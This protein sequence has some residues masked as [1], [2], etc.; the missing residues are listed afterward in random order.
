MDE[1]TIP[2]IRNLTVRD[3]KSA[4]R[5][6]SI[7]TSNDEDQERVPDQTTSSIGS[8]SSSS[9]ASAKAFCSSV[10]KTFLDYPE[11]S[12]DQNF[13]HWHSSF[14]G[15]ANIHEYYEILDPATIISD[16]QDPEFKAKSKF[17]FTVFRMTLKSP[18]TI[19]LVT[20]HNHTCDACALYADLLLEFSKENPHAEISIKKLKDALGKTSLDGSWK[21]SF[22]A[23]F[24]TFTRRVATLEQ[25]RLIMYLAHCRL[26]SDP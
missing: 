13:L 4:R 5:H 9:S 26:N 15:L 19:T 16:F 6:T 24:N 23:F 22:E 8:S 14:L 11:L 10:K 3:L 7:P 17:A 1:V 18:Q 20:T 21:R 12:H 25:Q 2:A